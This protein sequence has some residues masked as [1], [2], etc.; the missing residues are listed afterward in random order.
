MSRLLMSCKKRISTCDK[1][2]YKILSFFF[3]LVAF[4]LLS[5][6]Y[7]NLFQKKHNFSQ[8]DSF[9]YLI[10]NTVIFCSFVFLVEIKKKKTWNCYS[11]HKRRLQLTVNK[12]HEKTIFF[13]FRKLHFTLLSFHLQSKVSSRVTRHMKQWFCLYASN[14]PQRPNHYFKHS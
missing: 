9:K 6:L 14:N 2:V 7:N 12:R 5:V 13:L 4:I 3:I 1:Y 10:D 8:I 11:R